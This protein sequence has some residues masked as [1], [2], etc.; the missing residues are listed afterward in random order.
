MSPEFALVADMNPGTRNLGSSRPNN[1]I[2]PKHDDP[3]KSA[4]NSNNHTNRGQNVLY[5]DGHVDFSDTPY[6]GATHSTGIRDNIYT[7]GAGDGG[8]C[9]DTAMPVDE[10]DSVMLPTDDPGGK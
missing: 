2:G 1:V 7:A 4:A 5:A 8:A 9:S 6:C 3:D 10:K